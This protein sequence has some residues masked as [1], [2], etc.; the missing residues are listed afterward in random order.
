M[1]GRWAEEGGDAELIPLLQHRSRAVLSLVGSEMT[2]RCLLA[3]CNFTLPLRYWLPLM[4]TLPAPCRLLW[5]G[6]V[7]AQGERS[8]LGFG[9]LWGRGLAGRWARCDPEMWNSTQS[10]PSPSWP[11]LRAGLALIHLQTQL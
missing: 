9:E 5:L 3:G 11:M 10:S 4:S 8:F 6:S 2:E 7:S 1:R